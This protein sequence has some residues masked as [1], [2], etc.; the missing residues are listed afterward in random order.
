MV[1][2]KEHRP[3]TDAAIRTDNN[4]CKIVNPDIFAYPRIV[5]NFQKPRIFYIYARFNH[6]ASSNFGSEAT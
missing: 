6:Y 5:T 1:A 4:S 2:T 3:L